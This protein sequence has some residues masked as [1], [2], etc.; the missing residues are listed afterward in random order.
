MLAEIY[1]SVKSSLFTVKQTMHVHSHKLNES[2]D[3]GDIHIIG[4]NSCPQLWLKNNRIQYP[5]LLKM[6]WELANMLVYIHPNSKFAALY[7]GKIPKWNVFQ[8]KVMPV[9]TPV[10]D[11]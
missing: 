5:S 7:S 1:N 2:I 6:D 4:C 11:N 3:D 9:F 8:G 10:T